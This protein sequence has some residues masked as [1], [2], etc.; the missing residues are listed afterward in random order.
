M[1]KDTRAESRFTVGAIAEAS[2]GQRLNLSGL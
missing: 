1:E 2:D